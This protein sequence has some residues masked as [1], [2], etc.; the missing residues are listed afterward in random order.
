M[1]FKNKGLEHQQLPWWVHSCHIAWVI[2][3]FF[4][5]TIFVGFLIN[6]FASVI[7]LSQ[8]TNL[9]T[10]YIGHVFDWGSKHTLILILVTA[11]ML[12]FTTLV[13]SGSRQKVTRTSKFVFAI[14]AEQTH[15]VLKRDG[16]IYR[17]GYKRRYFRYLTFRFDNLDVNGLP[18]GL[19]QGL[20]LLPVF[21]DLSLSNKP[22]HHATSDPLKPPE[23]PQYGRKDIWDYLVKS[24]KHLVILGAPG[25]GKTTLV[26]YVAISLTKQKRQAHATTYHLPFLLL[27]REH[28]DDIK[29]NPSFFL[30]KAIEKDLH[31]WGLASPPGWIN[32]QLNKKGCLILLDGLDEVANPETRRCVVEWVQRQMSAY[33]TCRFVMTSRP[34]GY[35]ENELSNTLTLEV[36]SFTPEQISLFIKNW[37][38]LRENAREGRSRWTSSA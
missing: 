3:S 4:W 22:V 10:L 21:V 29:S 35:I 7:F 34:Y 38:L 11:I 25:S 16:L 30:T 13:W 6:L 26:K 9:Q 8:G 24:G 18:R 20:D 12:V 5:G 27:L 36:Q 1:D 31:R 19:E 32:Q 33:H 37:Y 2:L 15:V 14:P 23:A 28:Q 17:A